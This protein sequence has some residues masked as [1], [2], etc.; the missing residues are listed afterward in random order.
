[1][2]GNTEH[3][4]KSDKHYSIIYDL[5]SRF[6]NEIDIKDG[7]ND[8]DYQKEV[9]IRSHHAKYYVLSIRELEYDTIFVTISEEG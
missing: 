8:F 1:M 2:F 7:M 4:L 6:S 9:I 3:L 5:T